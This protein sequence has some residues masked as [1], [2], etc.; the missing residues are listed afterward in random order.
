MIEQ[1]RATYVHSD[2]IVYTIYILTRDVVSLSY[3]KSIDLL[4]SA[5]Y[6]YS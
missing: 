3:T 5:M 2:M 4:I 6:P 1:L